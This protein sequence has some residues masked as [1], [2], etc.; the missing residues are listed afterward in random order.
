[1][2]TASSTALTL[3]EVIPLVASLSEVDRD[4]LRQI[5][6]SQ[7]HVNWKTEWEKAVSHFHQ[8][9]AKFPAEEVEADLAKALNEVRNGPA[10]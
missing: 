10:H 3:E 2:S 8:A 6:A 5:L 7:P 4:T 9:F 1:M